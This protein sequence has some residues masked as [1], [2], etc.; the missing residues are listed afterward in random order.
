MGRT[1]RILESGLVQ[2]YA[3]AL[4]AVCRADEQIDLE[5]GLRLQ[6][7]I[8]ARAGRPVPLDDLLLSEPLDPAHVPELVHALAGPF[9]GAGVHPGELARMI[10]LDSISVV[11]AKGYVSEAEAQQIVRF[12]IAL[13]CTLDEVGQMSEHLVPWLAAPR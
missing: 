11:L 9:R 7:R 3:Q 12:A 10:V 1:P 6:Q 13:G 5:E 8:D 2:L 4:V